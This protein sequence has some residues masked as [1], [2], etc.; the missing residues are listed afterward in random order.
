M[1][2]GGGSG[3]GRPDDQDARTNR[4]RAVPT[5][6]DETVGTRQQPMLVAFGLSSVRAVAIADLP[7]ACWH[8]DSCDDARLAVARSLFARVPSAAPV[9]RLALR[10]ACPSAFGVLTYAEGSAP[11]S[12][13]GAD[14][15]TRHGAEPVG[16][17]RQASGPAADLVALARTPDPT[18]QSMGWLPPTLALR[19][20]LHRQRRKREVPQSKHA[21]C[22]LSAVAV[23]ANPIQGLQRQGAI[24]PLG[25][26]QWN[27]TSAAYSGRTIVASDQGQIEQ[28]RRSTSEVPL[29]TDEVPK[30]V[31]DE[32]LAAVRGDVL[33]PGL[34]HMGMTPQH[35]QGARF[36][37]VVGKLRLS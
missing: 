19:R 28:Q 6:E 8:A 27:V 9:I 24:A 3:T 14:V 4:V 5:D 36:E 7:L 32:G 11:A 25:H 13:L 2:W 15:V 18:V 34:E 16:K 20:G 37:H 12:L 30:G 22:E 23:S 31:D 1:L 17:V 26:V 35:S 21:H 33:L 10:D 29:T